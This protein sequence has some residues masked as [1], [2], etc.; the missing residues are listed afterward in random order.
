VSFWTT[1]RKSD[2]SMLYTGGC[3]GGWST[4][5]G[6]DEGRA[7]GGGSGGGE[8]RRGCGGGGGGDWDAFIEARDDEEV[9]LEI[10]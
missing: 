7:G 3:G 1:S 6:A 5:A 2:L 8:G 4:A 10:L 9:C